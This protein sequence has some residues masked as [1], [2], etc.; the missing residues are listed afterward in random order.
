MTII[1]EQR[2]SDSPYVETVTRGHTPS[3]GSTIRPA[4]ISWH[5]ILARHNGT[6]QLMVVGPLTTAGVVSYG[7]GAELLW[8]KFKVG[9][10]MPHLPA[11]AFLDKETVLPGAERKSFWLKGATWQFPDYENADT[12]VD[13][14]V[15]EDVL[16]RDPV[17]NAVLQDKPQAMSPR[18]VR[19]RFLHTT[20]LTQ[21][22][23]YQ[24]ERA[25]RAAALLRQG[26][27]IL[28]TVEEAGY[29]DQPHL[30]RA[31]KQWIGFTPA[32][33][34]RMSRSACQAEKDSI[35]EQDYSTEVLARV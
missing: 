5:M 31:L 21:T 25:Q 6:A 30:T 15:R 10:Y 16:V 11:R 14:L 2:P 29:F 4:E 23:I 20:G 26:T 1:F 3:A 8:I 22:H 17:V 28:D 19:H 7:E 33:I 32:Q 34:M 24:V 12:F 13:R 18:T 27:S 35:V 9:T